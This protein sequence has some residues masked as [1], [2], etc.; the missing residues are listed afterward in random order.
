[1]DCGELLPAQGVGMP[2]G[3]V[4]PAEDVLRRIRSDQ[5][6]LH[7]PRV[8]RVA[9]AERVTGTT[10]DRDVEGGRPRE[11]A[12]RLCAT[13]R[14]QVAAPEVRGAENSFHDGD[15]PRPATR[16]KVRKKRDRAVSFGQ[17]SAGVT[18]GGGRTPRT[19]GA[20]GRPCNSREGTSGGEK[21]PIGL[22][23]TQTE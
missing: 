10:S 17:G 16:R 18:F 20:D 7:S 22:F 9:D 1:M 14:V 11:A 19:L 5:H 3:V 21:R 13:V 2:A 8:E 4:P 15:A 12:R 23:R 6:Q